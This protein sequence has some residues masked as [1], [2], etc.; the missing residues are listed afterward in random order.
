MAA[1]SLATFTLLSCHWIKSGNCCDLE[2]F[3]LI[4]LEFNAQ[5]HIAIVPF[6]IVAGCFGGVIGGIFVR[7][8][9]VGMMYRKKYT[10]QMK[11]LE[12]CAVSLLTSFI[13]YYLPLLPGSCKSELELTSGG[14]RCSER[15]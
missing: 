8:W 15:G 11:I 1:T 6:S 9:H 5:A 4:Q 12:L 7:L 2:N 10:M 14:C 13:I 3:G